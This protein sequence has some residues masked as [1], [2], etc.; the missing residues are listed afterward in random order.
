MFQDRLFGLALI[1]V[2]YEAA[3]RI[4]YHAIINPF[5]YAKARKVFCKNV[6]VKDV[7]CVVT[8]RVK[9]VN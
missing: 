8:V 7:S 1:S 9:L 6:Y 4:D 2:E 3:S 5:A